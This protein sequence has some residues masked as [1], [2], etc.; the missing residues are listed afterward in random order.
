MSIR[1]YKNELMMLIKIN[2]TTT[3]PRKVQLNKPLVIFFFSDMRYFFK[4]LITVKAA[5]MNN[6]IIEMKYTM[7]L[8]STTPFIIE[9]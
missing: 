5:K 2:A 6:P 8:V 9:S 4:V 7:S 3:I 1:V